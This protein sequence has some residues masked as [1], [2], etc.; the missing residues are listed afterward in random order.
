MSKKIIFIILG[1]W[2]CMMFFYFLIRMLLNP[3]I[4]VI[5]VTISLIHLVDKFRGKTTGKAQEKKIIK[6]VRLLVRKTAH[7]SEYFVL[8]V[9]NLL[10]SQ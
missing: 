5:K 1:C 4:L 7:M 6:N 9:F 3:T 10:L 2:M 8:A